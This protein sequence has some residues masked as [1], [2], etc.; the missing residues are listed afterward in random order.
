MTPDF[1][2]KADNQD[3]TAIIRD[4]LIELRVTDV[5]GLTSDTV[6]IRLDDRAP[7]IELPRKGAKLEISLGYQ[8]AGLDHKGL[9]V[10]DEIGLEGPPDT[11]V[12]RARAAD[13]RKGLKERRTRSF[14]NIKIGDLVASIASAHGY[15]PKVSA[16]LA[17]VTIAHID[18]TTESDLELLTRLAE[19]RGAVAK[20]ANGLLLFVLKAAS[21]S[22]S[23]KD[24]PAVT[25]LRSDLTRWNVLLA[26]RG[27]YP[28]VEARYQDIPAG[29]EKKILVGSGTP[30]YRLV[31]KY[32]DAETAAAVAKSKLAV[33]A[34]GVGTITGACSGDLALAAEG[35]LILSGVRSGV[36]GEWL[37]AQVTHVINGSGYRCEFQ[38]ETVK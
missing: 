12:I 5:S 25:K 19:G 10:V 37:L 36:D 13:L 2:I 31:P 30:V 35:K 1:L 34:R 24:L 21:K 14:D 9:F 20:V 7:V 4:R 15:L 26:D 38:G 28:A 22:S 8:G 6:M 3:V 32:A 16:E 23:G 11:L 29:A 18:Q 27:T 33:L 17:A